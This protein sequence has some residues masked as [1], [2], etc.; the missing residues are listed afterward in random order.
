M[1]MRF[2]NLLCLSGNKAACSYHL[3]ALR[4]TQDDEF[5]TN[6]VCGYSPLFFFAVTGELR[7]YF[8]LSDNRINPFFLAG[9]NSF[10]SSY[11]I[12]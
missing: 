6:R 9:F 8:F 7:T 2:S 1:D 4:M 10:L 5:A 12:I 11:R 3:S